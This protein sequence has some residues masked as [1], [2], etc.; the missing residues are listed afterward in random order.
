MLYDEPIR[1]GEGL[2]GKVEQIGA[3]LV[4]K[5]WKLEF[6][7]AGSRSETPKEFLRHVK[8][9]INSVQETY[10]TLPDALKRFCAVPVFAGYEIQG[11]K[12]ITYHEYIHVDNWTKEEESVL[13]AL[14]EYYSDI[15]TCNVLYHDGK[16][17]L[18]DVVPRRHIAEFW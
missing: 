11:D 4:R 5:T 14:H 12:V 18:T 16:W 7:R 9:R 3:N 17:Y 8:D 2:E 10:E 6:Y 15:A 1:L 13:E